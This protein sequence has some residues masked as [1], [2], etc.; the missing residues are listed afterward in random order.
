MLPLRAILLAL[1]LP[2]LVPGATPPAAAATREDAD[3]FEAYFPAGDGINTL[4]ADVLRPK[5]I[6]PHQRTPVILTVSP[7]TNHSGEPLENGF[8]NEGPSDRFYDFLDL[9][10]ILERGYTYVMV[11]L[12][13]FGGSSGCNDWGGNRE[14][15]AVEAAVKWAASQRWSTGKVGMIGKSYDAWTGLMGVAQRPPGLE[16]VVAMEPVYAGYNYLYN[17]GV[18]FTNSVLTPA[19][20]Q[21]IDATPGSV[22]D[23]PEYQIN[24][25]PQAWCYGLNQSLQQIDSPHD[26]FWVERNLLP[27]ARRSRVPVFLTQGFLETNTKQDAAF[28]FFNGLESRANRAWYGQFDHVR[29]WERTADGERSQTGRSADAF[30]D[31]VLGFFA[32]H[33]KGRGRV[34]PGIQVQDN[35]GRYRREAVWPPADSELL[36]TGLNRGSYADDGSNQATGGADATGHGVWTISQ[37]LRHRAWLSGEPRLRVRVET[38][39]PRTNLVGLVYDISPSGKARLVSRG[40]HLFRGVGE[41]FVSFR[42]YGQDW[43]LRRGHR[44]GVL[45]SGADSSWWVHAP[46]TDTV[47]VESAAAGLPFLGRDR[48]RFL[49]GGSTPRLEE[50]LRQTAPVSDAT[51]RRA[52]RRFNLP[53]RLR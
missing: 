46:T 23:S 2:L 22:N 40:A 15:D 27:P 5:G 21:A 38:T 37:E 3:H 50:H 28:R 53:S 10:R 42:L 34:D 47:R 52:D 1:L 48:T 35:L 45:L 32:Q 36:W 9:S 19:L 39:A 12:P 14:Q 8:D 20:F 7:Y 44:I 49:A 18:R 25:A 51:V 26:P 4:H 31:Q 13:G 29:G 24:G 6:S 17:R 41:Q 11:D 33:L 30:V 16:A 43:V